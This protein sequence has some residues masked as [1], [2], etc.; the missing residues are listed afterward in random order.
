MGSLKFIFKWR[1]RRFLLACEVAQNKTF[2]FNFDKLVSCTA[3]SHRHKKINHVQ[4]AAL[5]QVV[6][7]KFQVVPLVR[8]VKH[9]SLLL[10]LVLLVQLVNEILLS[11]HGVF[12]GETASH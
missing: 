5:V 10:P 12:G 6:K 2:Y 3:R 8:V 7:V 4:Y 11:E 1:K 9:G